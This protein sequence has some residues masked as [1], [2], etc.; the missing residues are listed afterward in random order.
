[1]L[2]NVMETFFHENDS[3]STAGA[4]LNEILENSE[5]PSIMTE[6]K[7]P[8]NAPEMIFSLDVL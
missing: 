8:D 3:L 7:F 1:M 5:M 2:G 4:M 6:L